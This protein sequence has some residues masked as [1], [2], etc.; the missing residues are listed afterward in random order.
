MSSG[1]VGLSRIASRYVAIASSDSLFFSSAKPR[2]RRASEL[3]GSSWIAFR[4]AVTA[5]SS[6][7]CSTMRGPGR[8]ALGNHRARA[9]LR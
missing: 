9:R 4:R 3:S 5:S 8:S 1:V 7:S 6:F 2:V